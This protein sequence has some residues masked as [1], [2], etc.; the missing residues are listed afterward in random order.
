M[1]LA[2]HT[3]GIGSA[4]ILRS[5]YERVVTLAYLADHPEEG[6]SFMEYSD[7]HWYKL[8]MEQRK[9]EGKIGL[10]D[11]E[12]SKT[13]VAKYNAIRPRFIQTDCKKCD[14]K[15]LQ[16]SW[17]KK[18]LPELA[19]KVSEDIRRGYFRAFLV[20]T[21]Y[22]H[23]TF[24]GAAN[25]FELSKDFGPTSVQVNIDNEKEQIDTSLSM[26]HALLLQ[27]AYVFN[28]HFKLG[29]EAKLDKHYLNFVSCWKVP[30]I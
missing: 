9:A 29:H 21:F 23:T 2:G 7:I 19:E 22:I 5:F 28:N 16:S 17:T 4:K 20:P 3:C 27:V 13:I 26:S 30:S 14:T 10:G 24:F 8:I 18:G 15:R 12:E 11:D 25:Y 1:L 6:Q